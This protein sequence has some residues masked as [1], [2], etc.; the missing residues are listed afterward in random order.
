MLGMAVESF[1]NSGV[2]SAPG[3]SGELVCT[4]PFPCQPVR[5]EIQLHTLMFCFD[6]LKPPQ[7]GFWPLP[8]FGEDIDVEAAKERYRQSYFDEYEGIWCKVLKR[9]ETDPC[10]TLAFEI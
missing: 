5:Y 6:D 2:P 7:L 9:P 1:D 10:L 3:E 4:K 8:G